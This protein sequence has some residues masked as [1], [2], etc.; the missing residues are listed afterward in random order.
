MIRLLHASFPTRTIFLGVTE[1][2]V[3]LFAFIVATMARLGTSDTFLMLNYEQGFRKIIVVA[4]AFLVCM[5]YFDLYDFPILSNHREALTRLIQVFGTV[6]ILLAALY[7]VYPRLEL[8]RG[9]S[10]IGFLL[11]SISLLAWRRLFLKVSAL[12]QF[13]ERVLILGQSSLAEALVSELQSRS[14]LGLRVIGHIEDTVRRADNCNQPP[15]K[16]VSP[17]ELFCSIER[18]KPDR[19]IVAMDDR[20]GKLPVESL[21]RLKS[22]GVSIQDGS[23]LYEAVTGKLS[24]GSLRLGWLL[25]SPGFRVARALVMYKR[26]CSIIFSA[27]CL[28]VTLPLMALIA[29]AILIDSGGPAIFL[30]ER[31]GQ[32]GK[33]FTLYKFRSMINGA[34]QDGNQRPAEKMDSR[35][36]RVGRLLRRTRMDE[37][38]QL[39]NILRGDMHF[40][41]PRPFVPSQEQECLEHIPFYRQRWVVK[42]GATGWAQV[43]RGYNVT[44]EDNEEKLSYDLFYIKNISVGLDL[45][46]LFKTAKILLLGRGSQ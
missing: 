46:I 26:I 17:D 15:G 43:N 24:I 41:G 36:T 38:P 18:Y 33:V 16:E 13:S 6:C 2:G 30:Q 37:L 29:L 35:F 1:A 5:Y 4:A 7:Y 19:I 45:L 11:V 12:P 34:D 9:I 10:V 22:R 23:E 39:F 40:V 25:F 3:V 31:I 8:E 32:D 27:I 21:L 44:L 20:R 14:E 28:I 42:P